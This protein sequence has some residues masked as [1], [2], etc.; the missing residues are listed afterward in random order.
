MGVW[1]ETILGSFLHKYQC[2]TPY[3]GVWIETCTLSRFHPQLE[4]TPYVGVWIETTCVRLVIHKELSHPTWVCG[5]KRQQSSQDVN[6]QLSHPTWV[7][8]LKPRNLF[9]K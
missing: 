7:C 4:V 5:L 1:I 8:G 2:V 9:F 6:T 3:V